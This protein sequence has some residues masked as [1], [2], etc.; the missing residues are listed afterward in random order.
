MNS[1]QPLLSKPL[2]GQ[3]IV[4]VYRDERFLVDGLKHFVRAG[5]AQ[6]EG[7][8]VFAT[9]RHWDACV[10]ALAA[11]SISVD[12]AESRG[13]LAVLDA[14]TALSALMVDG[15]PDWKAFQDV[16]GTVINL[17]RRKF[18]RLRAFGEMVDLLW[19]RG[20]R[21]A[22]LRLEELWNNLLKIQDLALC[23]AYRIDPLGE[24]GYEGALQALCER[25]TH[26]I[27]AR[28]YPELDARVR[29]ASDALLGPR[30]AAM[31]RDLAAAERPATEMPDAQSMM[32]WLK[33]HMPVTAGKLLARLRREERTRPAAPAFP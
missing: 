1:W 14:Q 25:H 16:V 3:H 23:C 24:A 13:Q 5:L 26:F 11:D 22:A 33:V 20:E 15:M 2:E 8:A 18:P 28:D 21:N 30:I 27:P 19:Q 6:G 7:V 29:R 31:L 10:R 17:T 9:R 4:Q 32:L 12:I